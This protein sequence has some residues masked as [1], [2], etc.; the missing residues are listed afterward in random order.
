VFLFDQRLET[1]KEQDTG[2]YVVPKESVFACAEIISQARRS[3]IDF[4]LVRLDRPA[5]GREPFR[6]ELTAPPA[7]DARIVLFGHPSGLPLKFTSNAAILSDNN[8]ATFKSDLDAFEG[9]SGGPVVNE[10]TGALLGVLTS[11]NI[12]YVDKGRG[13][14]E[15]AE[16]TSAL[17]ETAMSIGFAAPYFGEALA[18]LDLA[19]AKDFDIDLSTIDFSAENASLERTF[20]VPDTAAVVGFDLVLD[21]TRDSG[22]FCLYSKITPPGAN[23]KRAEWRNAALDTLESDGTRRTHSTFV[24][25]SQFDFPHNVYGKPSPGTWKV[26]LARECKGLE[27]SLRKLT[28]RLYLKK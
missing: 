6:F 24:L 2:N 21:G 4:S 12:D 3:S 28:L 10:S 27:M 5:T 13:C 18:E 16:N 7:K 17:G 20:D 11:G 25:S 14:Q 15:V 1:L 8:T 9:N 26:T 23:E 22:M 19:K